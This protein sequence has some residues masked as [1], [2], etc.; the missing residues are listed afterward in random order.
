MAYKI[1]DNKKWIDKRFRK[2]TKDEKLLYMYLWD[3]C[4]EAGFYKLN[5]IERD[6]FL[7]GINEDEFQNALKGLC[8]PKEGVDNH[9]KRGF[10]VVDGWLWIEHYLQHNQRDFG[11]TKNNAHKPIY[12]IL[13]LH[14]DRFINEIE[15]KKFIEH[16]TPWQGVWKGPCNGNGLGNGKEEKGVVGEKG[17][18]EPGPRPDHVI[19]FAQTMAAYFNVGEIRQMH[20]YRQVL[21]FVKFHFKAGQLPYLGQQFEYYRKHKDDSGEIKHGLDSYL[22]DP[23]RDFQNGGW[24]AKDW[25]AEYE[26]NQQKMEKEKYPNKLVKKLWASLDGKGQTEYRKHLEGLGWKLT[27]SPGGSHWKKPDGTRE[28]L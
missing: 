25:K 7:M 13:E 8:T 24:N 15:F 4:N 21:A 28:W 5:D 18:S 11:D 2:L 10:I 17:D 27:N 3:V 20:K 12:K 22:G 14:L 1:S 23:A 9:L 26:Q 16:I 6:C 19:A